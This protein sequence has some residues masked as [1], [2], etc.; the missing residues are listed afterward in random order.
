MRKAI[1]MLTLFAVLMTSSFAA[2]RDLP[3]YAMGVGTAISQSKAIQKAE[4]KA[5]DKAE[6]R[7]DRRG[8][9]VIVHEI[10]SFATPDG[11]R[12]YVA[13]SNLVYN[14]TSD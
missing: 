12:L 2:A 14:C 9:D 10:E 4:S 1:A 6:D 3:R 7:C 8:G 11:A 5:L 13:Q